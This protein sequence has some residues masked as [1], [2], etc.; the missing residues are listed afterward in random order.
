M[1]KNVHIHKLTEDEAKELLNHLAGAEAVIHGP[2]KAGKERV[3]KDFLKFLD[4]LG[5]DN[6]RADA[7][8]DAKA[9][10][11]ADTDAGKADDADKNDD[12]NVA[13]LEGF[14]AS[15][16]GDDDDGAAETDDETAN[17]D[18]TCDGNCEACEKFIDSA[19]GTLHDA[20]LT[21]DDIAEVFRRNLAAKPHDD[22]VEEFVV[23]FTWSMLG[24]AKIPAHSF[25]EACDIL[26]DSIQ[27]RSEP[28]DKGTV[29]RN[30]ISALRDKDLAAIA[31][32]R[33]IDTFDAYDNEDG[34]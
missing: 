3:A 9:D 16:F 7:K 8:T 23:P 34:D 24:F 5:T 10:T 33:G 30:S 4:S 11:D 6:T 28:G 25:D 32:M 31:D 17:D 12:N 29:I 26:D 27:M 21:D 14:L 15:I 19:A 18:D 13:A 22:D 1:N 20:G 2:A